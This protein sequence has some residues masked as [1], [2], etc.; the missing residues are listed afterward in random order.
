M[1][2]AARKRQ[3]LVQGPFEFAAISSFAQDFQDAG[4]GAQSVPREPAAGVSGNFRE[5]MLIL[6]KVD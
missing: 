6:L 3:L 5:R 2:L 4:D 1:E